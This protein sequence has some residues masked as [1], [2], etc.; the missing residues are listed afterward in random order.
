MRKRDRTL[1]AP[2]ASAL[3]DDLFDGREMWYY[4]LAEFAAKKFNSLRHTLAKHF[5]TQELS[6]LC[7]AGAHHTSKVVPG[8]T[9]DEFLEDIGRILS[10][11]AMKVTALRLYGDV[12]CVLLFAKIRRL[13]MDDLF[14]L[15][16][17]V[18]AASLIRLHNKRLTKS[19]LNG[20]GKK[21][22]QVKPWL[23]YIVHFPID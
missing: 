3:I 6:L 15:C 17:V 20:Q 7:I 2:N 12:D 5:S 21:R 16:T 1:L 18:S 10:R 4:K 19:Q 14:V 23:K 22:V 13:S 9:C 8:M 11:P